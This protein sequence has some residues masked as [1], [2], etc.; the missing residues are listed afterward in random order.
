[1]S[2]ERNH[3]KREREKDREKERKPIKK[4]NTRSEVVDY[5]CIYFYGRNLKMVT[6]QFVFFLV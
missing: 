3:P 1:M 6:I 5:D 4:M 2:V